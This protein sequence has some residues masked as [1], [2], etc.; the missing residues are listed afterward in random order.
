MMSATRTIV[1][2]AVFVGVASIPASAAQTVSI[3]LTRGDSLQRVERTVPDGKSTRAFTVRQLLAGPTKAE[4]AD[5]IESDVPK[6]TTLKEIALENGVITVR[7]STEFRSKAAR[8]ATLPRVAQLVGTLTRLS[9][10]KSVRVVLGDEAPSATTRGITLGDLPKRSLVPPVPVG[11]G[12]VQDLLA[13][14]HYLP[15][16]GARTG[17][18][19]YRTQQA[20]TAFQAWEGLTRDGLAGVDTRMR[21]TRAKTP[22][23]RRLTAGKRVEVYRDKGVALLIVNREVKRAIHVSTGAGGITPAGNWNIYRKERNS[24][25][26]PFSVNLPYA[27]YFRGGYAFH[28]YPSVPA[29]PASHGCIRVGWPEAAGVYEFAAQN[30]PVTVF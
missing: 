2:V 15:T 23:A 5:G 22:T 20:L 17:E 30:T 26:R 19:D 1:A 13:E 3:Y 29:Y 27:S 9:G 25:S 24:W 8:G 12:A 11:I 6:G 10:V 28:Q 4:R 14:L 16:K 21:L 18:L 7:L